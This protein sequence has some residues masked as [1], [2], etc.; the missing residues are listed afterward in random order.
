L[1][2]KTGEFGS[3]LV[4]MKDLKFKYFHLFKDDEQSNAGLIAFKQKFK[5]WNAELVKCGIHYDKYFNHYSATELTFKRFS[6]SSEVLTNNQFEDVSFDEFLYAED[7]FNGGMIYLHPKC[8]VI[9]KPVDS[10]GY[11][12]SSF[13]PNILI[14]EELKIPTKQGTKVMLPYLDY[15]NLQY[16]IYKAKIVCENPDFNKIFAYSKKNTYTH[17]SLQF[18]HK[19]SKVFKVKIQLQHHEEKTLVALEHN[20]IIYNDEDLVSSRGIFYNWYDKLYNKTKVKC[21]KDNYLMKR[22]L[23]SLWGSLVKCDKKYFTDAQMEN[24]VGENEYKTLTEKYH[25]DDGE[26]VTRYECVKKLKP[27]KEHYARM[28]PYLLALSRNIVGDLIMKADLIKNI[29]RINTDGIVI[30]KPFDFSTLNIA[31]YP[32]PE[33]KTTGK[34][35]WNNVNFYEKI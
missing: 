32:K 5:K 22:L 31:Y 23:S 33:D 19:F 27:Y 18:A 35:I 4:N 8:E 24:E 30:D 13:Y 34:I 11:D 17:Y 3:C 29:I 16:G 2:D 28:K 15:E 21:S 12:Y 10:Y 26:M 25:Y 7:C 1:D 20:A 14:N 6:A 9:P